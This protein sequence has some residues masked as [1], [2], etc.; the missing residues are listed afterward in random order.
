MSNESTAVSEQSFANADLKNVL[1]TEKEVKEQAEKLRKTSF[2]GFFF[3]ILPSERKRVGLMITMFCLISFT[4]TFLRIFK[5]RIV[6]SVLD[7]TETKHWLKLLCFLATQFLVIFSQNISSKFN[8]NIA[9]ERLTMCF[10]AFLGI[11]LIAIAAAKAGYIPIIK[12]ESFADSI[13]VANTL[14]PRGLSL[15][16]PLVLV[17][18]FLPHA[19]FYIL[20]EV[21]GSLMVSFCFMTY[22]NN[23]T[24]ENQ[25]KRFVKVL[26]VFSNFFSFLSSQAASI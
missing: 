23:N 24:T 3:P 25:N 16:Y 19:I 20:S 13:F 5:D 10:T 7:N 18:N 22:L 15:F 12:N 9:F 14:S 26:Y 2:I 17:F 8:F 21:V 11:N 1:P 6:Y 4:Y